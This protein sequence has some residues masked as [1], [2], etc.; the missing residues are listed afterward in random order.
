[1]PAER[2]DGGDLG[3]GAD[4]GVHGVVFFGGEDACDVPGDLGGRRGGVS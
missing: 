2:A 1:M 3:F 4:E